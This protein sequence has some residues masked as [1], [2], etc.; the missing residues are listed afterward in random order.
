MRHRIVKE[1]KKSFFLTKI[2]GYESTVKKHNIVINQL[3]YERKQIKLQKHY[4][5]ECLK[6]QELFISIIKKL[7]VKE[8]GESRAK[9]IFT[10]AH[11]LACDAPLSQEKTDATTTFNSS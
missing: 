6:R 8:A 3:E 2:K 9:E 4:S 5:N 1:G 7:I 10:L 11:D